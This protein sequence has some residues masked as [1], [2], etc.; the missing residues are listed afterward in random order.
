LK[1]DSVEIEIIPDRD[2][3]KTLDKIINGTATF[4]TK[5]DISYIDEILFA[6][7]PLINCI[8]YDQCSK[9]LL[10]CDWIKE[11]IIKDE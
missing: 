7:C 10:K 11:E 3:T 8:N 5:I 6:P 2:N 4:K 1:V 9:N